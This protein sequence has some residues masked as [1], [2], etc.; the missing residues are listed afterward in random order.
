MLV[1]IGEIDWVLL[2]KQ[3]RELQKLI[4]DENSVLNGIVFLIDQIQ[5]SA[6]DDCGVDENVV[7]P[8]E[9]YEEYDGKYSQRA[10]ESCN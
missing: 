10:S 9:T 4:V 6:V 7:F 8:V 5:D 3:K 2:N 1:E